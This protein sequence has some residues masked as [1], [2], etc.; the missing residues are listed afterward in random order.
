MVTHWSLNPAI[1]SPPPAA[2]WAPENSSEQMSCVITA[3]LESGRGESRRF[4]SSPALSSLR[5]VR[6]KSAA[7]EGT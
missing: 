4:P 6:W 3:L 5:S 7:V 1:P 2:L